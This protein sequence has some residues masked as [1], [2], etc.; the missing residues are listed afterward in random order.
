MK[1]V[2]LLILFYSFFLQITATVKYTINE[3]WLFKKDCS[4]I[5]FLSKEGW[6][7]ID[8]PHTWNA[9]DAFDD[10]P[11]YYRGICWYEKKIR[12][13][14]TQ[15]GKRIYLYFE[16]VN[17][18][19]VVYVNNKEVNTHR[20][21][22]TMFNI[23]ITSYIQYDQEN[24]IIVKVDNSLNKNIPP[25]SADFTFFGG[26]YRDVYLVVK[27]PVHISILDYSSSGVYIRTPIVNNDFADV[28]FDVLLNNYSLKNSN[29]YCEQTI[30]SPKGEV[31]EKLHKQIEIQAGEINKK[32]QSKIKISDPELWS[33]DTPS[34]YSVKTV[35]KDAHSG[36]ILDENFENFGLR[37]FSFD[38]NKGFFLNGKPLK[39]IGTSRHQCFYQKGNALE[40]TYHINDVK[41]LKEMGGNFLR[42]SHYPQDP[43][44]LELCDK[45]GI[46]TSV[47]IPIVNAITESEDFLEN[48]LIMTNEM[49]K[50]SYNH[51]SVII[52]A[53]MN[54]VMLRP[55]YKKTDERYKKYCNE[56]HKQA[57][58]IEKCIR[59]LDASRYTLIPFHGSFTAYEDADLFNVPMIVGWNL[60]QGWYG[61][62]FNDFDRFL[63]EYKIKYPSIPVIITEYGADVDVRIHSDYPERFDYSV[64][65]GD[66]YHEHYLKTILSE[67]FI[68]GANIWNLNDFH[69]ESR[70]YAIPHINC[71]GITTLTRTP[72]NTYYLYK[73]N[74]GQSPFVKFA[75]TDWKVRGG[76]FYDNEIP[77]HKIKFYSN[78]SDATVYHNGENLGTVKVNNG[79]GCLTI[80]PVNGINT[81]YIKSYNKGKIYEDMMRFEYSAMKENIGND[82]SELNM[83]LGSKRSFFDNESGIYWM[84]EKEYKKGSWGYVGGEAYRPKTK[85]G[86]LPSS[87]LN[88]LGTDKDPMFQTQRRNITSFK[89]D[90]PDGKYYVY[91]YF[92]DLNPATES[93]ILPYNLG[94]D[95]ISTSRESSSFDIILNDKVYIRDFNIQ[96]EVGVQRSIIK[97]FILDIRD[98]KGLDI[99]LISLYG[100]NFLNAVRILKVD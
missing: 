60:Y 79:I 6:S 23:D 24:S 92:A 88:I 62:N 77:N 65:Y 96:R 76:V 59:E 70:G 71:K 36:I 80:V 64:E 9:E 98:N 31:L 5:D 73:A 11:G 57:V 2:F 33:V 42:I 7:K 69:S 41:L 50:Q 99:K 66:M 100:Y 1:K 27:D 54:E 20:G 89:A 21:G 97:K 22:Y 74:L 16:G 75:N 94:N 81:L 3:Q 93:E 56:V 86:S 87:N 58:S 61:G 43:L 95:V 14:K 8:L 32:Y 35:L 51:P 19:A 25:L 45:L 12:F 67:S 13:D 28:E 83:L 47:E 40:D 4:K 39:L 38:P 29:V 17:Q 63:D 68:S 37:W 48:S 72:K 85:Y 91:L 18:E 53:Y 30:Y 34:L 55:P 82:F 52:W 49:V 78:L 15:N 90:V 10:T 44:I 46:L 84:P 26:I